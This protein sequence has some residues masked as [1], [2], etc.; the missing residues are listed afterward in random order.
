MPNRFILNETS[1]HGTGAINSIADEAK[2]RGF[3]KAFVCSD[4]DLIKFGVTQKVLNVLEHNTL[5]YELYSN[6]KPNPTIENVQTGVDSFKKSKA[7]YLIAIGGGSSMD[8]AKAIGIVIANPDF[9]DIVS[10]EGVATTKNKSVPIFAVPTTA[11]TAAEVTIN[12]VITD[13]EKNRK[14]VCV[15]PK[16]IPVVAFVDPD[17]MSSMPKGLTAATGMDA[18]THAIEGYVTVGAWELSDMFHLK[19]I[20]IIS[21]SLRNAVANEPEGRKDMAL[22][23]YIAGMGFSNVG[24]GIVHSMAHPLGAFYDTPHGIANAIILPTVMEYN[25]D[26]TGDKYKYIAKAMG[27]AGTENMSTEEYRKAAIAAVK[28]LSE[29]V[30]IPANL[31]DIVN[32]KD[33]PFLAQSA[34]D[35]ACRPGN[36]KE[37]NVEDITGLYESLI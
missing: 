30:G 25:A 22:G 32:R 18:L 21:R 23:Q 37:T 3:K 2:A 4:P 26:A 16:D 20:E 17:M 27:V 13:V 36:P 29:D 15:D 6:I 28:K 12:Y 19:A 35:D 5:D 7:D 24:L 10:L 14:M 8:T 1:Y 31:K 9:E 11:G 33:I 34:Y